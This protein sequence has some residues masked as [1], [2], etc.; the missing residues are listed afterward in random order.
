MYGSIQKIAEYPNQNIQKMDA[1]VE[2]DPTA[3][4]DIAFP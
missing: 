3:F 2:H 1:D 4:C